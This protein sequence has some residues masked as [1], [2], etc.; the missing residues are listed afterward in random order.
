MRIS[1]RPIILFCFFV[2]ALFFWQIGNATPFNRSERV[3]HT[4]SNLN[5]KTR[6]ILI[7]KDPQEAIRLLFSTLQ[8]SKIG[9]EIAKQAKAKAGQHGKTLLDVVRPGK[10]SICDT[11]LVRRFS[12][13]NPDQVVY[14]SESIVYL[15]RN[16]SVINAI[17]DLAHE[18]THYIYKT[19]F[20]P[21]K[22]NFTVK[23][24]IQ[25]TI[26]GKGGEVEAYIAECGVLYDLFPQEAA[27]H[28]NCEKI[29]DTN[30][31]KFSK[32]KGIVAFYKIGQQFSEFKGQLKDYGVEAAAFIH[33]SE[34]APMFISSAYDRP[35]PEAAFLEYRSIMQRACENDFQRLG[36]MQKSVDSDIGKMREPA[37]IS[38]QFSKQRTFEY[39][40]GSY[41][42]RCSKFINQ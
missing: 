40:Q 3:L 4:E 11:T 28:S 39:M 35:Y 32:K 1:S 20:N 17:V 6:W 19:P 22:L 36:V 25:S 38:E 16:L 13:S 41:L 31:N 26:E 5:S 8:K 15:D 27:Q 24:F 37:S 7:H 30:S 2:F 18:L 34:E 9:R 10:T 12:K 21:Y 29:V 42:R 14:E 23:E 33:L